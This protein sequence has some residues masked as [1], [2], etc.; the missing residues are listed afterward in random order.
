M[1]PP[2]RRSLGGWLAQALLA[3][4]A[5]V[6]AHQAMYIVS[7]EG[8]ATPATGVRSADGYW[9]SIELMV[10]VAAAWLIATASRQLLRL[11]RQARQMRL[12]GDIVPESEL[13]YLLRLFIR[14]WPRVAALTAVLFVLQENIERWIIGAP[15]P[16][17]DA[18]APPD[19]QL[20]FLLIV[21]AA[22]AVALVASLV[23]WRTLVLR[24]RLRGCSSDRPRG[25]S[26]RSLRQPLDRRPVA[27]LLAAGLGMR[28]PP[29]GSAV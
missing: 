19:C 28:A 20:A 3:L 4:V 13:R 22:A 26:V 1:I 7:G 15:L 23:R 24:A 5:V 27:R 21:A 29:M 9:Q 14:A 11:R 17:L 16:G 2:M 10:A 18:L 12:G 8:A 6:L 25:S